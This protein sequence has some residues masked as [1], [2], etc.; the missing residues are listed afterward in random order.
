[1]RYSATVAAVVIVLIIV[2][3]VLWGIPA[4]GREKAKDSYG[5]V[6]GHLHADPSLRWYAPGGQ[7]D[8]GHGN[9]GHREHYGGPPGMMRAVHHDELGFRGWADMPG[10]YEGS[11]ASSVSGYAHRSA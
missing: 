4:L 2:A 10:D 1:M 3:I 7:L 8:N 9:G 11:S 5:G 6:S